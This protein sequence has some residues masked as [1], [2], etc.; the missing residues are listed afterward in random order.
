MIIKGSFQVPIFECKVV[1]VI[2]DNL[3][4][5]LNRYYKKYDEKELETEEHGAFFYSPEKA[6]SPYHLFFEKYDLSVNTINH[7]KSHLVEQILIDCRIKPIDEVRSYLD[8]FISS[9]VT[10]F[11]KRRKLRLSN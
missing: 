11:F 4:K 1:I 5:T 3:L 8:G 6:G 10:L 7:E 2:T 9:K